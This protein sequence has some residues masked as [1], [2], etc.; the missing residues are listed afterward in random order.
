MSYPLIV[1]PRAVERWQHVHLQCWRLLL[2][3]SLER[4]PWAMKPMSPSK[5]YQLDSSITSAQ[6]TYL[7]ILLSIVSD[8]TLWRVRFGWHGVGSQRMLAEYVCRTFRCGCAEQVARLWL[9]RSCKTG[10]TGCTIVPHT[11]PQLDAILKAKVLKVRL[12]EMM[13]DGREKINEE[14]HTRMRD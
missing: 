8:A 9:D 6:T 3:W 13:N 10:C 4:I 5:K 11:L 14:L 2:V 12:L 1:E 7:L